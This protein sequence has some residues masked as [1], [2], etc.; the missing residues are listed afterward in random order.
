ML[1]GLA[2]ISIAP[3]EKRFPLG[4]RGQRPVT[5]TTASEAAAEYVSSYIPGVERRGHLVDCA[6]DTAWL[7]ARLLKVPEPRAPIRTPVGLVGIEE[8]RRLGLGDVL[9]DYQKEAVRWLV[10]RAYGILGDPMRC[11]AA[12]TELVVN[13]AGR[14]S[15]MRLDELVRKL[16]GDASNGG[17]WDLN[18]PTCVQS[19]DE[20]KKHFRLNPITAAHIVGEK[21]SVRIRLRN[22]KSIRCSLD[23]EVLARLTDNPDSVRWTTAGTLFRD[24]G[25]RSAEVLTER[26]RPL[27]SEHALYQTAQ[28]QNVA[29]GV[30]VAVDVVEDAGRCQM[31]DLTMAD[32]HNYVAD[33]VVVHNSGK[34]LVLLA[35]AIALG[36]QKVLVA[37][38]ALS[39]WVWAD[40]IGKWLGASA[41][42]LEGRAGDVCREVCPA[43]WGSGAQKLGGSCPTCKGRSGTSLG[44][45]IYRNTNSVE[46]VTWAPCGER[47]GRARV[48][49]AVYDALE[50]GMSSED[51]VVRSRGALTGGQVQR[52]LQAMEK[53]GRVHRL[54]EA[55]PLPDVHAAI[56]KARFVIVNYD[57][58]TTQEEAD[59]IGRTFKRG[60]LPG[61]VDV[62]SQHKFDIAIGD[63]SHLLRGRP[64]NNKRKGHTRRERFKDA[65]RRV[66]RVWLA[67]GTPVFGFVRDL[68]G[69]L[70]A[71]SGGLWGDRG[72]GYE[73]WHEYDIAYAGGRVG[74]YGW[75]AN[76]KTLRADNE[77][78]RRLR[79]FGT[80]NEG[81]VM[82]KRP[83]SLI[84]KDMPKKTR[85]VVRIDGD[86]YI[87]H[88]GALA[89]DGGGFK[90]AFDQ[91][92]EQK[93]DTVCDN[94][95]TEMAEGAKV[96]AFT[97]HRA[98]CEALAAALRTRMEGRVHGPV[99]RAHAADLWTCH[100]QQSSE[101]RAALS[102]GF[103][104]HSG[105]GAFVATI[106][107]VQVSVSLF[108]ATSV[109]FVDLH[110]S[111]AAMFQAEDRPYEP[112]CTG[113]TIMYYVVRGSVDEHVL[114]VVLPKIEHIQSLMDDEQ[115]DEAAVALRNHEEDELTIE[116]I[117]LRVASMVSDVAVED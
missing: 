107:A 71:C 66:P 11:M 14:A 10:R 106:D 97:Y 57:I 116:E 32:P 114:T 111:P 22:G 8:Y 74:T 86:E 26:T 93:L 37:C 112:G 67:T 61:W 21:K 87:A 78:R 36:A 72:A 83:R 24:L 23:H 55:L 105:A 40:E 80:L 47:P 99:L 84:L 42:I 2:S 63:E 30:W 29:E 27:A 31:F 104:A 89:M 85:Q 15:H 102:K 90:S 79:G 75:E 65:V 117:M 4:A 41:V 115:A 76:G 13:R 6:W 68:W 91:T 28:H 59:P 56:E 5:F 81:Y 88:V 12:E 110:W 35:A 100:G 58:L 16:A 25:N 60:D 108:G 44:V 43:C 7:A 103:R 18:I 113:L 17:A 9:R 77:L 98:H 109:H 82:L 53:A 70:D 45:R 101:T 95:L 52:A 38:P 3:T 73:R 51:V 19:W 94:M 50:A 69:Q 33:G 34:S 96:V 62:I 49:R 92:F 46:A 48:Q 64:S 54:V 39:K 1:P 20:T